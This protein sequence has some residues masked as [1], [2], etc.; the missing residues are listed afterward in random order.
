MSRRLLKTLYKA[1]SKNP[2]FSWRQTTSLYSTLQLHTIQI[3]SEK[4]GKHNLLTYD[5]LYFPDIRDVTCYKSVNSALV[6]SK[7]EKPCQAWAWWLHI[8]LNFF[9][10]SIEI[11]ITGISIVIFSE[12]QEWTEIWKIWNCYITFQL[13]LFK[14]KS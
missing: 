13:F 12:Y 1:R 3:K 6:I 11:C 4:N 8:V 14:T 7:N 9:Y 5:L 10:I 2:N